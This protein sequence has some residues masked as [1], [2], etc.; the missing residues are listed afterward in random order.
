VGRRR[1]DAIVEP[2]SDEEVAKYMMMVSG[3]HPRMDKVW[4]RWSDRPLDGTFESYVHAARFFPSV[5]L[6]PKAKT[7][8]GG[9]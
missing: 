2:A 4:N 5:W 6:S 3:R 1:F 7:G 8:Q 9:E